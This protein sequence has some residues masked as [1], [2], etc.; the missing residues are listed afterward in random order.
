[1]IAHPHTLGIPEGG[2][3]A[4]FRE[5]VDVGL[6]GIEAYYGEYTPELRSH[7]AALCEDLGVVATGG[8]DYHGSYKPDLSVGIGRGDLQ[9]PD[10][11][12]DRLIEERDRPPL[13]AR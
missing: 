10:E 3:R 11:A 5:L 1:V 13:R 2:Y 6:G 9:V 4:A 8:S 12:V 7:L